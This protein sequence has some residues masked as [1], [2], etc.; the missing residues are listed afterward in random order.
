[1]ECNQVRELI[2]AY[3]DGELDAKQ[4][5]EAERH[6]NACPECSRALQNISALKTAM[7]ADALLFNV[8]GALRKKIETIVSK[9]ADP[10]GA[11]KGKASR[12]M[13]RLAHVLIAAAAGLA[14]AVG[15]TGYLM[16]PSALQR[17]EADAV[18]DQ[19]QAISANHLVEIASSDPQTVLRWL[20]AR[21]N[22]SPV[23]PNQL[24]MGYTLAGGRIDTLAGRPVAVLV[25][26]N[27][28][29]TSNLFQWPAGAS[30]GSGGPDTIQGLGVAAW[31]SGGMNFVVVADAGAAAARDISNTLIS[32]GCGLK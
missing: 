30:I 1:M 3:A 26:R 27:G 25:Y 12:P 8:P 22:F 31:N 32:Q 21:L 7:R 2:S 18:R 20:G 13:P 23:A 10:S 5:G 11:A 17:V 14:L 29:Q 19:R 24:A 6:V 16:W 9:A 15:I 28:P 4:R